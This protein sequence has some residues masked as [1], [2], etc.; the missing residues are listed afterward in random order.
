M[1]SSNSF[2]DAKKDMVYKMIC[3]CSREEG[4][5][6]EELLSGLKNKITKSELDSALDFLS[7]EGHVYSTVDDDHFKAIDG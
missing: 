4:I 1:A 7:G 3:G 2:G 5:D 6:R